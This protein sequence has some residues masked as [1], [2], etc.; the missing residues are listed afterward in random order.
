MVGSSSWR[1]RSELNTFSS[2]PLD[3]G[4]TAKAI[5]GAGSLIC[6]ISTAWGLDSSQS[7]ALVSL[8]FATAP[9]SPGPKASAWPVSLPSNTISWPMRS[10]LSVRELT[11]CESCSMTPW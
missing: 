6:G 11:T 9:M 1:R 4:V 2:S 10:L 5:T 7:P 3:L 8:S